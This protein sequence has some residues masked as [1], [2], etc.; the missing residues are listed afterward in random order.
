MVI[1]HSAVDV[2]DRQSVAPRL[3]PP[4]NA[5]MPLHR[6]VASATKGAVVTRDHLR[7]LRAAVRNPAAVGAI[8]PS[9]PSLAKAM[10]AGLDIPEGHAVLE[11]GPGTG[12]ITKAIHRRLKDPGAYLGIDRD[13]RFVHLLAQRFPAMRFVAGSA[14]QALD[15]L[16]DAGLAHVAAVISGIPFASLPAVAQDGIIECLRD[17]IGRGAVFRTFQYVHAWP[18]PPAVRFR[19]RMNQCFGPPRISRPVLLN[20]P[21]AFVLSWG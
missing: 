17:L 15:H 9:S 18:L 6:A 5:P 1:R 14:E 10:L 19:K 2:D 7:F 11:L 12:P 3:L 20:L 21:P 16:R 8:A 13:E 4:Y